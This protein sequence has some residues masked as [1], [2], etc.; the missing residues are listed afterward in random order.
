MNAPTD[1]GFVFFAKAAE[2]PPGRMLGKEI[3]E[4]LVLVA[5]V[6]GTFY[7]IKDVCTHQFARLSQGSL[8]GCVVTCPK[9][10]WRY[11]LRK[12]EYLSNPRLHVKCYEVKV[13]GED[14]LVKI[15]YEGYLA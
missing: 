12:G 10:A 7:S 9:H 6:D 5:N 14:I 8:R 3:G 2:I 1:P 15:P 4:A 11:D 13:E